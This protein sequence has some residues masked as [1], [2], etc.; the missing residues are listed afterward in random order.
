MVMTAPVLRVMSSMR[1]F[2]SGRNWSLSTRFGSEMGVKV[3]SDKPGWLIDCNHIDAALVSPGSRNEWCSVHVLTA[4]NTP[5]TR[6][7]V[8]TV[9][10]ILLVK[11]DGVFK[12]VQAWPAA[13]YSSQGTSG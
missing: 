11:N 9:S 2:S 13:Q 4:V 7:L 12:P 6:A 8:V 5:E 10:S 1:C 3:V